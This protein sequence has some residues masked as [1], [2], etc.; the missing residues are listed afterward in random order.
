MENWI[1]FRSQASGSW[2]GNIRS[3]GQSFSLTENEATRHTFLCCSILTSVV[4]KMRL[5]RHHVLLFD[6]QSCANV[7]KFPIPRIFADWM[8]LHPISVRCARAMRVWQI[9]NHFKCTSRRMLS[10][11]FFHFPR[12]DAHIDARLTLNTDF[13]LRGIWEAFHPF[14]ISWISCRI[15]RTENGYYFWNAI[16]EINEFRRIRK[17]E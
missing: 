13:I 11:S 15:L 5:R 2:V 14:W 4:H 9:Q 12:H 3:I 6:G 10:V 16:I 8:I 7:L 17:H 1:L